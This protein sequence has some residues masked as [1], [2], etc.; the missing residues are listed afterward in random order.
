MEPAEFN[1]FLATRSS[2]REYQP[3]P[4]GE[5][6][7]SFVLEC[8]SLAPSAGNREAWDI[9]VVTDESL[10]E[11]LSLAA[12]NQAHIAAAPVIFVFCANY[13]RSM[14]QYG[15]RGILY[16]VQDT[17]IAATYLMLAC[18]ACQVQTCWTGAFDE[19]EVRELLSLP[20]HVRPVVM[21][22]A[23]QG[24]LPPY[25]TSRMPVE[26]HVHHESW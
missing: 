18:H 15:D 9:V 14:S 12:Y 21:L 7:I 13:I 23:G 17:T 3:A 1:R 22:A 2:V 10:R 11:E 16:A 4:P 26:E 20:G 5:E 6:T 8:A 25:R 24:D 19:D